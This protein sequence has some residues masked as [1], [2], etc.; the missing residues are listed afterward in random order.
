MGMPGAQTLLAAA[1][2]FGVKTGRISLAKMVQVL[3]EN[4]ARVMG[5]SARKGFIRP[6]ADADLAIIDPSASVRADWRKLQH[7]TDF[8]PWQGTR[9]HGFPKYTI[10]RGKII[11]EAGELTD[12]KDFTGQF[13]RRTKPQ[14]I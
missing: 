1:Y 12:P 2:T 7:N 11:A 5:L 4:P 6:G 9:L 10:L 3:C 8:S 13:R 14:I